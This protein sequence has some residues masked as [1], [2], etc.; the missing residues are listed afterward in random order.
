MDLIGAVLLLSGW[1]LGLAALVMLAAVD[2]RLGF[3]AAGLALEVLGLA[4]IAY[5]R[6][7]VDWGER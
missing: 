4:V 5:R 6:R 1:V 3:V 2:Q 7:T